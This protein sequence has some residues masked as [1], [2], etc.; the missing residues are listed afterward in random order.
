VSTFRGSATLSTEGGGSV[1]LLEK[2]RVVTALGKGK[3]GPK[4]RIPDP[5]APRAP[6]NNVVFDLRRAEPVSIRWAKVPEALRYRLQIAR[7]RLFIPDS[8]IV[9]L[10][11]RQKTEAIVTVTEDGSFFWRVASVG[12]ANLTSEWSPVRRFKVVSGAGA[13][14]E[15]KRPPD[16]V[17][18]R[19][20]V[21]GNLVMVSGKTEPGALVLVNGE[22]VDPDK[23]GAFRKMISMSHD[24]LSTIT[25]KASDGAGN[26]TVRQE[27]V[28]VQTN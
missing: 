23:T 17:L 25:V 8:I 6:E 22:P 2:E 16:L 7:S 26:E 3:L 28:L 19:S 10:A 20:K 1:T 14:K 13:G 27:N 9:D 4:I 15:D 12:K 11:D 24:G 18:D 21:I 5:P